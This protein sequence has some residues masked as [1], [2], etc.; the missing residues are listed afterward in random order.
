MPKVIRRQ[1]AQKTAHRDPHHTVT[2]NA[3][4]FFSTSIFE[5]C[6]ALARQADQAK[7]RGK[8]SV[9]LNKSQSIQ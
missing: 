8:I 4:F 2:R 5:D 1:A 7:V 6:L 9:N 3:L